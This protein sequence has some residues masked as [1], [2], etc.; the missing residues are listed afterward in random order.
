MPSVSMQYLA[1]GAGMLL[2]P[3]SDIASIAP[4]NYATWILLVGIIWLA[5]SSALLLLVAKKKDL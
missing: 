4:L 2:D 5:I 3:A 1:T